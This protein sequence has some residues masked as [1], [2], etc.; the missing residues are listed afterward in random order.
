MAV[1]EEWID[2]QLDTGFGWVGLGDSPYLLA[3]FLF[4]AVAS[5]ILFTIVLST[6]GLFTFVFRRLFAFFTIC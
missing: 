3:Q 6:G 4:W 1:I 2:Q 5:G